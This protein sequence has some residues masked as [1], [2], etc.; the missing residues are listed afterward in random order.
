MPRRQG[1]A[2]LIAL[3]VFG[4]AVAAWAFVPKVLTVGTFA[5]PPPP[6][7]TPPGPFTGPAGAC[8]ASGTGTVTITPSATCQTID[9]FGLTPAYSQDA[10]FYGT[11]NLGLSIVRISDVQGSTDHCSSGVSQACADGDGNS[12]FLTAMGIYGGAG[13]D[14]KLL[15]TDWGSVFSTSSGCNTTLPPSQFGAASNWLANYVASVTTYY[16]P[17][18]AL[19]PQNEPNAT[20]CNVAIMSADNLRIYIGSYVGP[21]LASHGE[22]NI[23]VLAP[24]TA[25]VA[26]GDWNNYIH[27]I[28]ND[29]TAASYMGIMAS[30]EY[31]DNFNA[32]VTNPFI[33]TGKPLWETESSGLHSWDPSIADGMGWAIVLDHWLA[34]ANASAWLYWRGFSTSVPPSDNETLGDGNNNIAKRG[35]IIGNYAKFVRPGWVMISATHDPQSNVTVTAY[36]NPATK[37]YAIVAQNQGSSTVS[38]SFTAS[39]ATIASATP[40]VTSGS[41]NLAQQSS[42]TVSG[43]AFTYSLPATSVTTFVG[44]FN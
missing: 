13:A 15:V 19:S 42:L 16:H 32:I 22:S 40:W 44:T 26:N 12:G 11:S 20:W 1:I 23:K 21:A 38:Q 39:G 25:Q 6:P 36:K 35:Y 43:G 10:N 41:L 8:E 2:L 27:T 18:Y 5:A 29:S 17:V 24:E 28:M 31:D 37:D 30:H 4:T 14:A 9:G 34:G 7:P 3:C 33:G